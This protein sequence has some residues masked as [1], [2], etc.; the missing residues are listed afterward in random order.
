MNSWDKRF[1][2]LSKHIAGWSKDRSTGVSAI[3]VSRDNRVLSIGYNGFPSGADDNIEERHQRPLKY[4]Y[5]EHAERNAIY[6]AAR[7][8]VDI[9]ESKMYLMWFPCVDC[10]RAII[11]SGIEEL[12]CYKPDFEDTRWGEQF[13]VAL[14]LLYECKVIVRFVEKSAAESVLKT[15]VL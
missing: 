5:T 11:Q 2:E 15:E 10:A 7:I 13:R 3:I 14:D 12:I 1:I 8:G 4:L 6:N 9:S